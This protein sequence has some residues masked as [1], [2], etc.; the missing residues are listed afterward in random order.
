MKMRIKGNSLR[1]RV[2]R[3]ELARLG[4]GERVVETSR[5]GSSPD[6]TLGYSLK[7]EESISAVSVNYRPGWLEVL[8]PTESM[9]AWCGNEDVGIYALLNVGN[10][11]SLEVSVEKDY[12]CLDRSAEDNEDAF[13]NPH[14]GKAC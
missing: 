7:S 9:S 11:E 10:G 3:S 1:L 8:V 13:A 4:A 12:A 5:F 14:A 2:G 6:S